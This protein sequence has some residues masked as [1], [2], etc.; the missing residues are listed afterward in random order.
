[1][2]VISF[3]PYKRWDD[4]HLLNIIFETY[5]FLRSNQEDYDENIVLCNALI[6]EA[7][8]RKLRCPKEMMYRNIIFK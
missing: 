1:M 3:R 7:K 2:K 4:T 5:D 6:F 8:F